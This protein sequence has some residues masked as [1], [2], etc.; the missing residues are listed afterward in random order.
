[1]SDIAL[2]LYKFVDG[3]NDTPFPSSA[4]QAFLTNWQYNAKRMGGAPS[5]T[6]GTIT[7]QGCLDNEWT[8]DVCVKFRGESYFATHAPTSSYTKDSIMYDH[9]VDFVS[10]RVVLDTVYFYD[11]ISEE[12]S[13]GKPV[14]NSAN[15]VFNGTIEEYIARLNASLTK[16]HVGYSVVLDENQEHAD[17]IKFIKFNSFYI[18][19]A[20]Q[21]GFKSYG[22]PYYFIGKICHFGDRDSNASV[23]D[24]VVFEYGQRQSLISIS[25]SNANNAIINRITGTGSEENIPYY[26]PNSCEK[27]VAETQVLI[28]SQ[29]TSIDVI[30]DELFARKIAKDSIL[31]YGNWEASI[32]VSSFFANDNLYENGHSFNG[33]DVSE[34]TIHVVLPINVPYDDWNNLHLIFS[35]PA[36]RIRHID[37]SP[38]LSN[39]ETTMQW[40]GKWNVSIKR[41]V[42]YGNLDAGLY[43]VSFDVTFG[44]MNNGSKATF[45]IESCEI[46]TDGWKDTTTENIYQNL[47][48]IGLHLN[49]T[50][51]N[52]DKFKQVIDRYIQPQ[53][54]LMPSIYRES[55]GEERFY[56]ADNNTYI[57]PATGE[58]YVFPKPYVE[59][60]PKEYIQDN[61]DIKPT[62]KGMVND[63]GLP[64][65]EVIKFAFDEND[66]DEI[67]ENGNH[68]HPYFFA[69][70]HKTDGDF[71][72]NLFDQ[73]SEKGEMSLSFKSGRLGGCEFLIGVSEESQEYRPD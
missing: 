13:G 69:L 67:D 40:D 1:M 35:L 41:N 49:G 48:D 53:P 44:T 15:F 72:F 4:N 28:G 45:D 3:V 36:H 55:D 18:S 46:N 11:V 56:N 59:G 21:E 19:K 54:A 62:I 14:S 39:V 43:K 16:S 52:G 17:E 27:G 37:L 65:D 38:V 5:I 60:K 61:K 73:A 6:G 22:I 64:I 12:D 32:N 42:L 51:T 20:L 30:D 63:A 26:Y 31:Q 33:E 66:S 71:G 24:N 25:K 9:K 50:A 47:S 68:T 23:L 2:G 58:Y 29:I 57:N 7:Y 10:E 70:L 34:Q 8:D